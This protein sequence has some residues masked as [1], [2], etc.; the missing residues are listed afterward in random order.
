[1]RRCP[2]TVALMFF[3][4]ACLAVVARADDVARRPITYSAVDTDTHTILRALLDVGGGN[5]VLGPDVPKDY[6]RAIAIADVTRDRAL[7]S[8]SDWWGIDC[9]S[10]D[11]KCI[12]LKPL[13]K[14]EPLPA[15]PSSDGNKNTYYLIRDKPAQTRQ[16]PDS[17]EPIRIRTRRDPE[18][19]NQAL[20]QCAELVSSLVTPEML[21][22]LA[23]LLRMQVDRSP[24]LREQ[25]AGEQIGIACF[26]PIGVESRELIASLSEDLSTSM[27]K[28]GFNLVERAQL[29]K[30]WD[31]LRLQDTA[32]I[33]PDTAAKLGQMTGCAVIVV[34]SVCYRG[35]R[36]VINARL[37][38]TATGRALAADR[39]QVW[40]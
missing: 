11:P 25:L 9:D 40:K 14:P 38:E 21:D 10:R 34:G 16:A 31:E 33:D 29:D 36:V 37:I 7:K 18:S 32:L 19:V 39:V 23:V 5:Y 13:A 30:A 15:K 22:D 3:V 2:A 35:D 1:M 27:V 17:P 4:F 26:R 12:I 28:S 6:I 20:T 24:A 8:L